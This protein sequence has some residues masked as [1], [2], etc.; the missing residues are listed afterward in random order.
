MILGV[1]QYSHRIEGAKA[2]DVWKNKENA[3][4]KILGGTPFNQC[5]IFCNQ[6]NKGEVCD[7][8]FEIETEASVLVMI[9]FLSKK[10]KGSFR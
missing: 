3:I 2:V 10:P 9:S 1:K 5:I 7:C 4:L 8:R 6:R